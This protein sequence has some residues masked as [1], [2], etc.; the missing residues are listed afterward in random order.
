[1]LHVYKYL[2]T[3]ISE[4]IRIG[5]F[6]VHYTEKGMWTSY[7]RV[8]ERER[9]SILNSRQLPFCNS[10]TLRY[11]YCIWNWFTLEICTHIHRCA[12]LLAYVQAVSPFSRS[13]KFQQV[14]SVNYDIIFPK[15]VVHSTVTFRDVFVTSACASVEI[16]SRHCT[17]PASVL[18]MVVSCLL[19]LNLIIFQVLRRKTASYSS[20]S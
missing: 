10:D 2:Y 6:S 9:E 15:M 13:W 8:N 17:F 1:M 4:F 11:T 3:A 16:P 20:L 18:S 19:T 7:E 5:T 14:D 12:C